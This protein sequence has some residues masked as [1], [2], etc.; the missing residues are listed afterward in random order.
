M[1]FTLIMHDG[2][3]FKSFQLIHDIKGNRVFFNFV[4]E[5]IHQA[6]SSAFA[7]EATDKLF[8]FIV[9][10]YWINLFNSGNGDPAGYLVILIYPHLTYP[11]PLWKMGAYFDCIGFVRICN[12]VNSVGNRWASQIL[13][14]KKSQ[15]GAGDFLHN[16]FAIGWYRMKTTKKNGTF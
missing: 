8:E 4:L 15:R 14:K 13:L 7:N 10:E 11:V 12:V 9:D 16:G 6:S 1:D 2:N 5:D 3:K